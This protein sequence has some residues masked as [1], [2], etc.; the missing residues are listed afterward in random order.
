[1][2]KLLWLENAPKFDPNDKM[3]EIDECNFVDQMI[4]CSADS[5]PENLAKLQVHKHTHTC[6]NKFTQKTCRFDIPYYPMRKTMTLKPFAN[7]RRE[8][9]ELKYIKDNFSI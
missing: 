9:N 7:K 2:H 6:Y 5:L 1:V 4:S 8:R 3:T